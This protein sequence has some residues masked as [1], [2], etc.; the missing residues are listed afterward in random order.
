[1]KTIIEIYGELAL[2]VVGAVIM[3]GIFSGCLLGADSMLGK[4]IFCIR[5]NPYRCLQGRFSKWSSRAN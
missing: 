4:L 5:G 2:A 1:M 3:F